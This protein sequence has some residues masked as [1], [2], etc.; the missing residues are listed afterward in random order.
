[1][2]CWRGLCQEKAYQ[3]EGNGTV[4]EP[5]KNRVSSKE[6]DLDILIMGTKIQCSNVRAGFPRS[7]SLK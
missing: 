7:R 1:M 5:N 6:T 4:G 3:K 2:L